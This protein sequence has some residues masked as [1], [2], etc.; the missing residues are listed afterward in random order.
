MASDNEASCVSDP[1]FAVICSFLEYFGKSCGISYPDIGKLQSMLEDSHDVP[2]PLID[3]HIKLLRKTRKSVSAEKWE[4]AL[5]KFCHTYSNQDGWEVE[6]FGYKKVRTAVKVRLLKVLLESQFDLNQK[7]KN[8]VNKLSANELRL[9]PLGRDKTGQSY[10]FQLDEECNM[11][12]YRE[13]LD[14]ESWEL[15]A[16]DREGV[17][18]LITTLSDGEAA[19]IPINE[20]SNSL[21]ISEKPITDTGQVTSSPSL[22]SD[23]PENGDTSPPT[24]LNPPKPPKPIKDPEPLDSDSSEASDLTH[25]SS[26]PSQDDSSQD[27]EAPLPLPLPSKKPPFHPPLIQKSKAVPLKP[28]KMSKPPEP[29]KSVLKAIE[30]PVIT[31]SPPKPPQRH[32]QASFTLSEPPKPQKSVDK[33]AS[34]LSRLQSEKA[35]VSKLEK[36]AENLARTSGISMANG[37]EDK[38]PQDFTRTR[39]MD[40]TAPRGFDPSKDP[41]RPVDFS[42]MDLSKSSFRNDI[43]AREIDLSTRKP[44]PDPMSYGPLH[45]STMD[46]SKRQLFG[47]DTY[48]QRQKD[49]HRLANYSILPDPSKLSMRMKRSHEDEPEMVKRLRTDGVPVRKRRDDPGPAIEEPLMMIQGEGSG[50]DCDA[51]NPHPE[52][53]DDPEIG[54]AI[55]DTF[56]FQGEGSGADC[57]TGNPGEEASSDNKESNESKDNSG[58]VRKDVGIKPLVNDCEEEKSNCQGSSGSPKAKFKPTL[59]VQVFTKTPGGSSKRLSRWDVRET[60]EKREC[61]SSITGD[62]TTVISGNDIDGKSMAEGISSTTSQN[63]VTSSRSFEVSSAGAGADEADDA[64][65]FFFGPN[66]VS[67][68]SEAAGKCP[69]G[70]VV[71]SE[72]PGDVP[73]GPEPSTASEGPPESSQSDDP[74]D[75]VTNSSESRVQS[76]GADSSEVVSTVPDDGKAPEGVGEP[77]TTATPDD[78]GGLEEGIDSTGGESVLPESS[79]ASGSAECTVDVAPAP[80]VDGNALKSPER[81]NIAQ[82]ETS[83]GKNPDADDNRSVSVDQDSNEAMV[84]D[85]R[86]SDSNESTRDAGKSGQGSGAVAADSFGEI[87]EELMPSDISPTTKEEERELDEALESIDTDSKPQADTKGDEDDLKIEA[88][89]DVD[90]NETIVEELSSKRE[91]IQDEV[92]KSEEISV[93]SGEN[94]EI[95][96]EIPTK[97][98]NVEGETDKSGEF[99]QENEE[100]REVVDEIPSISESVEP[101]VD[102]SE[103]I[104]PENE[105]N[106]KT[107]EEIPSK[108][109]NIDPEVENS[110]KMS[111]ENEEN[112]QIPEEIPSKSEDIDPESEKTVEISPGN[113]EI[114]WKTEDIE[115][116]SEKT[117]EIPPDLPHE[118]EENPQDEP[119]PPPEEEI[120]EEKA[121]ED[122][123]S[124]SDAPPAPKPEENPSEIPPTPPEV[125][126]K[127]P[128]PVIPSEDA[129][130]PEVSPPEEVPVEPLPPPGDVYS[131]PKPSL[132][133]QASLVANYGSDDSNLLGSDDVFEAE[134][135]P[136]PEEVGS[137]PEGPENIPEEV[138][139]VP[140]APEEVPE[141]VG[142]TPEAPEAPPEVENRSEAPGDA[143]EDVKSPREG[144]ETPPEVEPEVEQL[145]KAPET[146][147]EEVESTPEP[148]GDAPEDPTPLEI[149]SEDPQQKETPESPGIT[150]EPPPVD[151]QEQKETESPPEQDQI[152]D[153]PEVSPAPEEAPDLDTP[154]DSPDMFDSSKPETPIEIDNQDIEKIAAT[155]NQDD[156]DDDEPLEF[157]IETKESPAPCEEPEFPQEMSD[158]SSCQPPEEDSKDPPGLLEVKPEDPPKPEDPVDKPLE[159][160]LPE[161]VE[162]E[163]SEAEL[164][165]EPPREPEDPLS[166]KIEEPPVA[167]VLQVPDPKEKTPEPQVITINDYQKKDRES[168]ED[169]SPIRQVSKRPRTEPEV[170]PLKRSP[171]IPQRER[172]SLQEPKPE[173]NLQNQKP[174]EE[175]RPQITLALSQEK[176]DLKKEASKRLHLEQDPEDLPP[177][178]SRPSR[179]DF[180]KDQVNDIKEEQKP[181]ELNN[182]EGRLNPGALRPPE[183]AITHL[184]LS[185]D[186]ENSM[187]IDNCMYDPPLNNVDPLATDEPPKTEVDPPKPEVEPPKLGVI[188]L[189]EVRELQYANW[190]MDSPEPQSPQP[191]GRPSRKRRNSANDSNSEERS[192]PQEAEDAGG[193]RMKLRG[194]RTPDVKLRKSVEANRVEASS[195]EDAPPL[196]EVLKLVSKKEGLEP[197]TEVKPKGKRGRKRKG[198]RGKG[199]PPLVKKEL[200]A[201]VDVPKP[202]EPKTEETPPAQKKRKKR[203]MVLGLEIG[204]DIVEPDGQQNPGETPVRQSR[205]IAQIKIKEE[206]DRRRIEEESMESVRPTKGKKD[207]G[208]S[209]KKR[210]KH[211]DSDEEVRI[212]EVDRFLKEKQKDKE[213]DKDKDKSKKKRRKRKKKEVMMKFNEAKPWQSSSGSSSDTEEHEEDEEEEPESEGSLLFKSDHEFSPESDLE[214][215]A[216]SEPLRRA[217]TAQK[218]EERPEEADEYACQ[219]CGKADH[220]EWIL[221]CDTCDR[222]WHCSCL[223]PALM[224]IPEGDWFCPPCQHTLLIN[225]LRESLKTYDQNVKKHEN[226]VL[227][228]KRLAYVGISLDNVLPKNEVGR[229]SKTR[230]AGGDS[231]ESEEESR[232]ESGSN[233]GSNSNGSSSSSSSGSG[234]SSSESSSEES[235]PVYQL[236]ERRCANTSYKFNEYDDMIN[237]AI[238]DEVEAVQGAGN[239]GRGKDIST[240]V[241]AEKEETQE[242]FEKQ[243][244]AA[245]DE[246]DK[247]SGKDSDKD[248]AVEKE[249]DEDEEEERK[250][251]VV[252]KSLGKKKHR[253]LNSL[254]ISSEDDPESDEDFKGSSSDYEEDYEDQMI[255]SDDSYTDTRRKGKR[256]ARPVRRSTRAAR[257]QRYD[258]DFI[259]DDSDDSDRPKRKKSRSIWDEESES[260]ESDNSWRSRKKRSKPSSLPRLRA[261]PKSKGKKKKKRK[262]IVQM[263]SDNGSDNDGEEGRVEAPQEAAAEQEELPPKLDEPEEKEAVEAPAVEE[264]VKEEKPPVLQEQ[265]PE[266]VTETHER[267]LAEEGS[268][269]P[270]ESLED[271]PQDQPPELLPEAPEPE[272]KKDKKKR[273]KPIR[274]RIIYGGLPEDRPPEDDE[275]LGRRTRGRKINYQV[276]AIMSDSEEELK[277]ALRKTE[278]SEDEFVMN[279]G[280]DHK[281]DADKNSDSADDEYSPQK[282]AGAKHKSPKNRRSKKS[283]AGRK[284]PDNGEPK[285]RKKPGPKPGSKNKPRLSKSPGGSITLE[286]T[287]SIG[288]VEGSLA[289]LAPEELGDLNDEQLAQMMM[290][291]EEYG[292][293]QLELAAIE[294]AKNKKK[295]EREAKKLEKARQ[296]ALEILAAEQQRD[297]NAP[298]GAEGEAPKKKKRGRRSKAEILA[299]QMRRGADPALAVLP[300]TVPGVPPAVPGA[301]G[302]P[303]A[304]APPAPGIP[305][306]VSPG[307]PSL[308][309]VSILPVDLERPQEHLIP[310]QLITGPDGQLL[311]PDGSP[312]KPKRR[313]RGKGKKTLAMEAARAEAA[314]KAAGLVDPELRSDDT[315]NV[316]PTPGSS[317]S[318]SAPSTP[319]LTITQ[320][321]VSQP[322]QS[323]YPLPSQQSSVITRM[324][325]SQ[326]ISSTAPQSFTAAAAAMG[327]KYFG[328]P[329]ASMM[330]ARGGYDLPRGRIPSPYNSRPG[331]PGLPVHFAVRSGAPPMRMRVPGPSQL[332]HTPHHPMDPSPSGGGPISITSRDRS[333]PLAPGPAMIPP[334]AGSP[335]AKGGPT[336]PPPPYAR[337][338]PLARFGDNQI[339]TRHPIPPFTASGNHSVQQPSPPPNRPGNFSPYHPQP[340]PNYHYGAYPPPPMSSDD[341]AYQGSPYPSEHFANQSENPPAPTVQAPPATQAGSSQGSHNSGHSTGNPPGEGPPP[342]PQGH[343]PHGKYDEEGSGEFGGL[344]SYFSSQREDDLDS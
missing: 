311:N 150:E 118:P 156:E 256:D 326:P 125:P 146:L 290:E 182:L 275:P 96:E 249:E 309:A 310:S 122:V 166:E 295:E 314:A 172:N 196:S 16:K 63:S 260:E 1:N 105:E 185:D 15:V 5:V 236:R 302:P 126:P 61:D 3:L 198:F 319:P 288:E 114:P 313:G 232:E 78:L 239:Q 250:K 190:K 178:K 115:P 85:D 322:S 76:T 51:V 227:R 65:R 102:E 67:Y 183:L 180:I 71:G 139:S 226:E 8:E 75:V 184:N 56:F 123:S 100:N 136:G 291:D 30:T 66:C 219:K 109:E 170:K 163:K 148:S 140:E 101:A 324:L 222:G 323:I 74:Q 160:P 330:G 307:M 36:I 83:E 244:G 141:V 334:A 106:P 133:S 216:E 94:A 10:W 35:G 129:K 98:E 338:G 50:S 62:D 127:S 143:P 112:P 289:S 194:K 257:R 162:L 12:V 32:L 107:P 4:K 218:S 205:R 11:R 316:L 287:P 27:S 303:A 113:E 286:G 135:P 192:H 212:R 108:S 174:L 248:Y 7:F 325:Q 68:T 44:K 337:G 339:A 14:E 308:P 268:E 70:D 298:E 144:P 134:V 238:Q 243:K 221:L 34:T 200:P 95:G 223:R 103:G 253:K 46:L 242:A 327:Q 306:S 132:V 340:P 89:G 321:P 342:N 24:P 186:S 266:G 332:Y 88:A 254:D 152:D 336:P 159:P 142:A 267:K 17:V 280:E 328:V 19:S 344:V 157:H 79:E 57:D 215:D 82:E 211:K 40:L 220:P 251:V 39:G 18:N 69:G 154:F 259:N 208:R 241:N 171:E 93:D 274:R 158:T 6:R 262:R 28:L 271:V 207:D 320:V 111:P 73:E 120:Q 31:T 52:T 121:P 282:M 110:V 26:N 104:S 188:K 213:N 77:E 38:H 41:S 137:T 245:E 255:S 225:K 33:L 229:R 86:G 317:T 304:A 296:K 195:D 343:G 168:D 60:D 149:L 312:V 179:T 49:D 228:K 269:A 333:S 224:L 214:K 72:S 331:G 191:R 204:I 21:E 217:R 240:I 59:G 285:Q 81:I 270:P 335:L 252:R 294:I 147:P 45:R 203:K 22:D 84:I 247:H 29:V 153:K 23:P 90:G 299:E 165:P 230:D 202:S 91:E 263:E 128:D 300:P 305:L 42:G 237:A 20:D 278:D 97:S 189:R 116:Q 99:R 53:P 329:N 130:N 55:E 58:E 176:P 281:N 169:N 292:R 264:V 54:E 177:V 293:R 131:K 235:E 145:P 315:S 43:Q 92:E 124:P 173:R 155:L 193:K 64:P 231:E 37:E 318:G 297:P 138:E 181:E 25:D 272:K 2:Q 209:K 9:E 201:V 151:P 233:A 13:D 164:A 48:H 199:R 284:A 283:P 80:I 187:G 261:A 234:S 206:A 301:S 279:D 119:P 277:K 175:L 197:L 117:S 87:P 210:R 273:E 246:A 276:D 265:K 258:E 161:V 341:A 47:Y 167:A